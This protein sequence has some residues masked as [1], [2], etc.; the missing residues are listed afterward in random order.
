MKLQLNFSAETL[1]A[2]RE[3]DN[4]FKVLKQKPV[5]E[6]YYTWQNDSSETDTYRL[7]QKTKAEEIQ[8]Y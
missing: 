3:W 8:H 4:T 1:K 6:E 2:Q 7:S 5:N